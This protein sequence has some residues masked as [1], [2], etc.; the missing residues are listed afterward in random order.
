MGLE[1]PFNAFGLATLESKRAE[2]PFECAHICGNLC[3]WICRVT[4][5][6]CLVMTKASFH[7]DVSVS[8]SQLPNSLC[9]LEYYEGNK[10][11]KIEHGVV[12]VRLKWI[13][14]ASLPRCDS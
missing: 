6:V 9:V 14:W 11:G 8:K 2:I 1:S 3:T 10:M 5:S 4:S 7:I 13:K 12:R